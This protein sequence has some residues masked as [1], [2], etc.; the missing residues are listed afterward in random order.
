[1]KT[2]MMLL[3]LVTVAVVMLAGCATTPSYR[4]QSGVYGNFGYGYYSPIYGPGYYDN[5]GRY[6]WGLR[7]VPGYQREVCESVT[8]RVQTAIPQAPPSAPAPLKCYLT[9]EPAHYE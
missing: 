9:W 5:P 1:M 8:P 7:W 6:G 2:R 3:M 4:L